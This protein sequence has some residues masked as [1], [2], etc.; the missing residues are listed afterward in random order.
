[1]VK[2]GLYKHKKGGIYQVL[3][4]SKC[5]ETLVENV[6]YQSIS[7]ECQIWTRPIEQWN[8]RFSPYD[9]NSPIKVID[10][11]ALLYIKDK[12]ILTTRSKGKDAL[13]FPGGKRESGESDLQCLVRE[14]KEELDV[15]IIP[16]SLAYY[17]TYFAQAH[18][19]EEGVIVK[20][21]CYQADF[22]GEI[23]PCSEIEEV[24]WIEYKDRAHVSP[25]DKIIMDELY[26]KQVTQ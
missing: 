13:Y 2:S 19:R 6:I 22:E 26:Y 20:M 1:M 3:G 14:I 15:D 21:T 8:D 12:K 23:N 5:S 17:G 18:G 25:V 24:H 11:V 4:V 10:K 7:G 9:L 16:Q